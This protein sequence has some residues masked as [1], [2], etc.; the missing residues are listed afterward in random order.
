MIKTSD[1][2]EGKYVVMVTK[3]GKIKR[4]ALSAYKNVRKNG[5]IAIGLDDGDEIAGVRM[6]DGSAQLSWLQETVWL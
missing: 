3:N 2:D 5:L 6:T 4:T 1:F